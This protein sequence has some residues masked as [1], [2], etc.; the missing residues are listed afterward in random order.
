VAAV[1]QSTG[2]VLLHMKAVS[3]GQVAWQAVLS[4]QPGL[5]LP[6]VSVSQ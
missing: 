4:R 3:L 6:P 1:L 2:V 5:H